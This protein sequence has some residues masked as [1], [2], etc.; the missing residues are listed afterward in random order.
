MQW[1]NREKW[2]DQ[3]HHEKASSFSSSWFLEWFSFVLYLTKYLL[4]KYVHVG[5]RSSIRSQMFVKKDVL[6]KIL[7]IYRKTLE[8]E[9]LFNIVVGLIAGNFIK[10][11]TPTQVFSCEYWE[12]FENSFFIE[13]MFIILFR[14]FMQW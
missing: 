10:K 8:L 9:S 12:I 1:K 5:K 4:Q 3:D 7:N 2:N 11:E 13:N 6:K 14:N